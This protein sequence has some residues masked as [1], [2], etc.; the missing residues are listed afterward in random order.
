MLPILADLPL[1]SAP[2]YDYEV[3]GVDDLEANLGRVIRQRTHFTVSVK[4]CE[5]FIRSETEGSGADYVEAGCDCSDTFVLTSVA[6]SVQ[7]QKDSGLQVGENVS[8]S[9]VIPGVV[10]L[11]YFDHNLPIFW[12][13]FASGPSLD[14]ATNHRLPFLEFIGTPNP[15]T[16]TQ[17]MTAIFERTD[18]PPFLART[19]TYYHSGKEPVWAHRQYSPWIHPPTF[20]SHDKPFDAGFINSTYEIRA[21]TNVGSY[22]FPLNSEFRR[23]FPQKGGKRTN[24]LLVLIRHSLVLTNVRTH[25]RRDD[26]RP[27]VVGT[28]AVEDYRFAL[29]KERV[30]GPV[31]Y[32]SHGRWLT[33]DQV[34]GLSNFVAVA[35]YRKRIY[36][37]TAHAALAKSTPN[38]PLTVWVSGG[39]LVIII[40]PWIFFLISRKQTVKQQQ[41]QSI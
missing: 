26:F 25:S 14:V 28:T 4:D 8:T 10:P 3:Q 7:K 20:Q 21:F 18:E 32:M 39:M 37:T 16:L 23:Y 22:T 11:Y 41:K 12:L 2:R 36:S 15:Y 38:R 13:A 40:V 33:D 17:S 29:T 9:F 19:V 24:D 5:W 1:L 30:V 27:Q 6:S 31:T 34:M 35:A